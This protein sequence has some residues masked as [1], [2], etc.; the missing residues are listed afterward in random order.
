MLERRRHL[1]AD[2]PVPNHLCDVDDVRYDHCGNGYDRDND[3]RDNDPYDNNHNASG[4]RASRS[5]HGRDGADRW[6]QRRG[7][8]HLDSEP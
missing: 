1:H 5:S 2:E 3:H 4:R 6:R 8:D 7:G